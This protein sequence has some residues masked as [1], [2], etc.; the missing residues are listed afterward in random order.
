M[1]TLDVIQGSDAWFKARSGIPT[2]SCFDKIITSSG[3]A[4]TQHIAYS[5][6]LVAEYAMQKSSDDFRGK[7]MERGTEVEPEAR[8]YYQ[9]ITDNEVEEVGLIYKDENRL[10]SCS[11]DCLTKDKGL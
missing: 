11:P 7:W 1:I 4:S 8:E 5:N 3:K 2:A 6:K 9:F 10:V